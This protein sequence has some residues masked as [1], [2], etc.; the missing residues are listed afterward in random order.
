M[1]ASLSD[2]DGSISGLRWQWYSNVSDA[3]EDATSDTYT[4][5]AADV[6]NT[7]TLNAVASYTDGHAAMKTANVIAGFAVA[8]D[9][10]N[11]PPVFADQDKKTS[12]VQNETATREVEENTK[13]EHRRRRACR[14]RRRCDGQRG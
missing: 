7:V 2:P 9:T 6:T 5:T 4:P 13:G 12:G 3:I 10:R 14:R 11:K 8:D 1:T